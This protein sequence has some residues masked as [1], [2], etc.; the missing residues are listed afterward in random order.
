VHRPFGDAKCGVAAL[1]VELRGTTPRRMTPNRNRRATR[2]A[3]TLV[4]SRKCTDVTALAPIRGVAAKPPR[5]PRRLTPSRQFR[6]C[7]REFRQPRAAFARVCGQWGCIYSDPATAR[8]LRLGMRT[9][10]GSGI[11]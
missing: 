10:E 7:N 6:I 8:R 5:A 3:P 2:A 11:L 4:A 9:R 1:S